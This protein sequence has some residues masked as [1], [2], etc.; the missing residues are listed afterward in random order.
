MAYP[1]SNVA[2][3]NHH[4]ALQ[5]SRV[6]VVKGDDA[7]SCCSIAGKQ[8]WHAAGREGSGGGGGGGDGEEGFRQHPKDRGSPTV[9]GLTASVGGSSA[10][11]SNS[12]AIL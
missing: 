12:V 4:K 11:T 3:D 7:P 2:A 5:N 8:A 6:Q 1:S 9:P 10:K